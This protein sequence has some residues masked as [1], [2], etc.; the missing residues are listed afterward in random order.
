[1]MS[2][3][4]LQSQPACDAHENL[5][6]ATPNGWQQICVA[7]MKDD[8]CVAA[9]AARCSSPRRQAAK[10]RWTKKHMVLLEQLW[11]AC[12]VKTNTTEANRKPLVLLFLLF[13]RADRLER[14]ARKLK[15]SAL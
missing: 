9:A 13:S 2:Q 6:T 1:M 14:W 4:P 7:A 15:Q 3:V 10:Q 5:V 11:I 12:Q 8:Q